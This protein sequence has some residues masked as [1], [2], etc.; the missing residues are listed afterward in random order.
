[1]RVN[2]ANPQRGAATSA[3]I[4][5]FGVEGQDDEAVAKKKKKGKQSE[6][7]V[8]AVAATVREGEA[9]EEESR[10]AGKKS[11]DRSESA[12]ESSPSP[13]ML[14]SAKKSAKSDHWTSFFLERV[15]FQIQLLSGQAK[16]SVLKMEE[17]PSE[18]YRCTLGQHFDGIGKH[19]EYLLIPAKREVH[20]N[21]V[22]HFNGHKKVKEYMEAAVAKGSDLERAAESIVGMLN[23]QA[24]KA[25]GTQQLLPFARRNA[26]EKG[27]QVLL[28]RERKEVALA[29]FLID[30]R[31]PLFR[32]HTATWKRFCEEADLKLQKP[33]TLR[34]VHYPNIFECFLRIRRSLFAQAGFLHVE[35]DFFS[36][37]ST[38]YLIVCGRTC[39]SFKIFNDILGIV[40]WV[41]D[42]TDDHVAQLVS[43]TVDRVA[44]DS[45]LLST[46]T[47]DGALRSAGSQ[48]VGEEDT[49]WCFCHQTALPVKKSLEGN[50]G[51]ALD[52]TFMHQFGVYVRSH[53][54]VAEMLDRF[55]RANHGSELR[56]LMDSLARWTSEFRKVKRFLDMQDEL[57]T[58]GKVKD[59]NVLLKEWVDEKKAPKDALK[60]TFFARL[61]SMKKVLGAIH[62][63]V[64]MSQSASVPIS[65]MV[66]FFL[67]RIDS[68]L[69]LDEDDGSEV[70]DWKICFK[71][72][73][74]AQ[75]NE[76][77]K[78]PNSFLLAAALDPR[79]SDLSFFGV[80]PSV[81]E[82]V[83]TQIESEHIELKTARLKRENQLD[84]IPKSKLDL[85]VAMVRAC[86]GTLKNSSMKFLEQVQAAKRDGEKVNK[87]ICDLDPLEWWKVKS[88]NRSDPEF[89]ELSMTACMLLSAPGTTAASERGVGRARNSL[90]PFRT[91]LSE[92]MLEQEVVASHFIRSEKYSF[93]ELCSEL[94]K[95]Q[96]ELR[97]KA[98]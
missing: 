75:F 38:K 70:Q 78:K 42:Q 17:A 76:I 84:E 77:A 20:S 79:F 86:R 67:R 14:R 11:R 35:F 13:T 49:T 63:V 92:G 28:E 93:E 10:A 95:L 83:W 59:V 66:L 36:F 94:A 46:C 96:K 50:S 33:D 30:T 40:E 45:V 85:S 32:L 5:H 61:E 80:S 12:G 72:L 69:I 71:R 48:L 6:A 73:F 4:K 1:L 23:E 88:D 26:A 19:F 18:M 52:F 43:S 68:A 25:G 57:M 41:G 98:K 90:T 54:V 8:V 64:K 62:T 9:V 29:V 87:L 91:M 7:S 55:R 56:L 15:P 74:D 81:E 22:E 51:I 3:L 31:T 44:N 21:I 97:E 53:A 39:I 16:K 58:L 89:G 82:S 47:V 2:L 27:V 60:P 65:S 34:K 24:K 37:N